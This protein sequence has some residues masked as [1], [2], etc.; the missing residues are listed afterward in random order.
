MNDR[1]KQLEEARADILKKK[2]EIEGLH[3]FIKKTTRE[4]YTDTL[5]SRA[6]VIREYMGHAWVPA[7]PS[8]AREIPSKYDPVQMDVLW[9]NGNLLLGMEVSKDHP[10]TGSLVLYAPPTVNSFTAYLHAPLLYHTS[11][12]LE[13]G[14]NLVVRCWLEELSKSIAEERLESQNPLYLV[15]HGLVSKWGDAAVGH[16][17]QSEKMRNMRWQLLQSNRAY[18]T[19]TDTPWDE[20]DYEVE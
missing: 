6:S 7:P 12:S 19:A 16:L 4:Q 15:L 17:R 9:K 2:E 8:E 13:V 18:H 1:I 3:I 20:D 14:W 11:E 5:A 10:A